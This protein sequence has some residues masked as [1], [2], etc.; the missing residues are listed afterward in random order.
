MLESKEFL[1]FENILILR[2]ILFGFL[3]RFRSLSKRKIVI[4]FK[5]FLIYEY[6]TGSDWTMKMKNRFN[7]YC[8]WIEV[9]N[10]QRNKMERM[11]LFVTHSN[12]INWFLIYYWDISP[13]EFLND[14]DHS[15]RLT[16]IAGN[17]AQEVFKPLFVAQLRT[18]GEEAHLEQTNIQK[19]YW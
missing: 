11:C 16:L 1:K 17:C 5:F 18:G 4:F 6:R 13:V 8:L 2:Q 7:G 14:L 12:A 19:K 3:Y 10:K 9:L 15:T